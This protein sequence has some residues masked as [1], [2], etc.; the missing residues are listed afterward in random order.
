MKLK[1]GFKMRKMGRDFIV[2]AE[3]MNTI[4]FNR[5]I[6]LNAT[7]A[8]LWENLQGREFTTEDMAAMLLE[9]Y[10]VAPEVAK[11]D[12]EVLAQKW[13]EAGIAE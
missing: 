4:N 10:E 11:A 12:S 2:T 8:Y 9:K 1:E 6:S 7:A 13:I 3:G 5:M